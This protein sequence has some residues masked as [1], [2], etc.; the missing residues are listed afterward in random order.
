MYEERPWTTRIRRR[1]MFSVCS[2]GPMIGEWN[3]ATPRGRLPSRTDRDHARQRPRADRRRRS[4][5]AGK[6]CLP[7]GCE[8]AGDRGLPRGAA[9]RSGHHPR[10]AQRGA[11]RRR[12]TFQRDQPLPTPPLRRAR[13]VRR[14]AKK[15]RTIEQP[16]ASHWSRWRL[17]LWDPAA[18]SGPKGDQPEG[19][20]RHIVL[21]RSPVPNMNL[22]GTEKS[23]RPEALTTLQYERMHHGP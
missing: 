6:K 8:E 1:S 14:A 20:D 9:F 10:S 18:Q 2:V 3:Q 11:A 16:P 7:M 23:P 22:L 13:R 12:P 5:R 4:A 17:R 19:S 15:S 21:S